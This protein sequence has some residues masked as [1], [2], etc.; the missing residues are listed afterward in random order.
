MTPERYRAARDLFGRAL[1]H[2]TD[3]RIAF[4]RC[5]AVDDDVRDEVLSLLD[6]DREPSALLAAPLA[7]ADR[8]PQLG[9]RIGPYRLLDR[10]G[11]GGMG[12]VFRAVREDVDSR[13]A[14]KF[15]RSVVALEP[16]RFLR[17]QRVLA[18]LEH[19]NIAR[20]LDA[21]VTDDGT[22]YLVMELV[23]GETITD[24]A[25]AG[26]IDH[27]VA[28]FE[29][30]CAAVSFAHRNLIVHRDLKPSNILVVRTEEGPRVKLL[31]F[32]IAKILEQDDAGRTQTSH[33]M[34]PAYAAPEQ[35]RGEVITTATDVYA[36]GV[37]LYELL[38]GVHP[39][40]QDRPS[41][42][43]LVRR[44][45]EGAV[46]RPSRVRSVPRDLEAIV[47]A[48]LSP[49]ATARYATAAELG[50]D[51][52]RYARGLPVEARAPTLTYRLGKF[53]R[54][55]LLVVLA[56][57]LIFVTLGVGFGTAT[58]Q[59][60][61]ARAERNRAEA[62][63]KKATATVDFLVEVFTG[64][65][66]EQRRLDRVTAEELALRGIDRLARLDDEPVV[67]AHMLHVLSQVMDLADRGERVELME[68]AVALREEALGPNHPDTAASRRLLGATLIY[69]AEYDRAGAILERQ[70]A[71]DAASQAPRATLSEGARGLAN[72]ETERGNWIR[73]ESW[74]KRVDETCLRAHAV[75]WVRHYRGF[76]REGLQVMRDTCP[77][78]ASRYN[79]EA[80]ALHALGE[81]AEAE[82]LYRRAIEELTAYRVMS[83]GGVNMIVSNLAS[84]L[85]D[86]GRDAEAVE[87][88]TRAS[89]QIEG[90]EDEEAARARMRRNLA[91]VRR[92]TDPDRAWEVFLDVLAQREGVHFPGHPEIVR[93]LQDL[94]SVAR[95]RGDE[96]Q[97]HR[98]LLAALAASWRRP[99][100][101]TNAW[102]HLELAYAEA[103]RGLEASATLH[104]LEA[105][106]L[107]RGVLTPTHP[108]RRA[109]DEALQGGV[110]EDSPGHVL[111]RDRLL[112][113]IEGW[114]NL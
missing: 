112:F 22:P 58:W 8:E 89:Q 62:E 84:L 55:N 11:E 91:A 57:S 92:R 6:A 80:R 43:Q 108:L 12:I 15:A 96:A 5:A 20:L 71:L 21:G 104:L 19:P 79:V 90:G 14:I 35:L 4:V 82:H 36:L 99:L 27:I 68:R 103:A 72:L 70:Y 26:S 109:I 38:T 88:L 47:L 1:E 60:R 111:A 46:E 39:Y 53:L 77:E 61:I 102:T 81:H 66:A 76:S 93:S 34:T 95:Q 24:D 56:V 94:G 33:V 23:D 78:A 17:E 10:I 105:D 74:T 13:V 49:D 31:D 107:T 69:A 16:E 86:A 87:V 2:P 9:R 65:A 44:V 37:V 7:L 73:A 114:G 28:L 3:E 64:P 32:G 110:G 59:A 41:T 51:L 18:A 29:Q 50:A 25:A 45:L 30:V 75:A 42:P 106:A 113:S 98:Y 40:A 101:P 52:R 85:V 97:G 67:Q 100:H 48:A 63:L 83:S 54:K